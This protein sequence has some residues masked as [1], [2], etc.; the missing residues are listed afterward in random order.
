MDFMAHISVPASRMVAAVAIDSEQVGE[1]GGDA[2]EE[3]EGKHRREGQGKGW[4]EVR[5]HKLIDIIA[6]G[7]D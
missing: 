5:V 4:S 7:A 1:K 3:E 6:D 2:G